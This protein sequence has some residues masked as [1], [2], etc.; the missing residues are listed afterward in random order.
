MYCS[1]VQR[2]FIKI[3]FTFVVLEVS[4]Y[5]HICVHWAWSAW[6][7]TLLAWP[8]R[9]LALR[10]TAVNQAKWSLSSRWFRFTFQN[11]YLFLLFVTFFLSLFLLFPIWVI[12]YRFTWRAA[13]VQRLNAT[14]H[15]WNTITHAY[16]HI[17]WSICNINM[18]SHWIDFAN[19]FKDNL[20]MN[21][22]QQKTAISIDR[23]TRETVM[24]PSKSQV[25]YTFST[26]V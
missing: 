16:I 1:T 14:L 19:L 6:K 24:K 7:Q 11:C 8:C 10:E 18:L 22:Q 26:L 21:K 9:L 23:K 12:I 5:Q 3:L 25:D 2:N 15:K 4:H 20:K 13:S 17:G